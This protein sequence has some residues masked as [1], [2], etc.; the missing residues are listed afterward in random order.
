MDVS[1]EYPFNLFQ[2]ISYVTSLH[3]TKHEILLTIFSVISQNANMLDM[4]LDGW[5]KYSLPQKLAVKLEYECANW[6][7]GGPDSLKIP[8]S[9]SWTFI[10]IIH[11]ISNQNVTKTYALS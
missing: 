9:F 2:Y 10:V 4:W 3:I 7:D 1:F 8:F 6:I 11:V 5:K